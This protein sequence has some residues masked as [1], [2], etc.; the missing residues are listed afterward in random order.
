MAHYEVEIKT[1]LGDEDT[2]KALKTKM[3]ELDPKSACTSSNTQLN[4][5]FEGG[6]IHALYQATEH[7][8]TGEQHEKFK[9]IADAAKDFSVRT[10]L[11]ETGGEVG[12]ATKEVRLVVKASLD[13]GTSANTVTRMEFEEPVNLSLEA[14][15]ELILGA[16]FTYQAKWS[17]AR[18]EYTYKDATVCVDKNAGYGYLAEF[19]KVVTDP[20][21]LPSVRAE[22]QALMAELEVAE[23]PQDRLARMFDHY[24]QNW[25]EYYG[26]DRTFTIE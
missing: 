26:T 13:E 11:T 6:D 5:Y 20:D 25:S 19:E 24:N 16:G 8:F 22:L 21:V 7:L 3:C 17:R 18:E 9:K 2:A 14:L 4:H 23:L 12:E 1:L 10:R 15:D